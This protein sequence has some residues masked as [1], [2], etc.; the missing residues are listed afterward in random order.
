MAK[1]SGQ[2][3]P[4]IP[5]VLRPTQTEF[6]ISQTHPLHIKGSPLVTWIQKIMLKYLILPHLMSQTFDPRLY[7]LLYPLSFL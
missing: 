5:M 7:K 4:T 3:W 1:A 2:S 6:P